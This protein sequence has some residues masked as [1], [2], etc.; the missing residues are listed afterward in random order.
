MSA[1]SATGRSPASDLGSS[2]STSSSGRVSRTVIRP[3]SRSIS[4]QGSPASSARR[5]PVNAAR[6]YNGDSRSSSMASRNAPVCCGVHTITGPGRHAAA[7]LPPAGDTLRGP[8]DRPALRHPQLDAGRRIDFQCLAVVQGGAQHRGSPLDRGLGQRR[9]ADPLA[10]QV[11]HR[12]AGRG[13]PAQHLRAVALLGRRVQLPH[14]LVRVQDVLLPELGEPDVPERRH[15]VQ[16]ARCLRRTR[17]CAACGRAAVPPAS[18]RGSRRGWSAGHRRAPPTGC[19]R[20][21]R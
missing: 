2:G 20:A 1:D 18:G 11:R 3:A 21:R 6:A 14:R 7:A 8:H 9:G 15:P 12:G 17:R 13:Q 4:D 16:A 5:S 19:R 10:G